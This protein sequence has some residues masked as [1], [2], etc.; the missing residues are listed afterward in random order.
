MCPGHTSS[1][2]LLPVAFSSSAD[3]SINCPLTDLNDFKRIRCSPVTPVGRTSPYVGEQFIF[4]IIP[5]MDHWDSSLVGPDLVT[6][7][8]NTAPCLGSGAQPRTVG[9]AKS[10]RFLDSA[11]S[12][13]FCSSV[14]R[15]LAGEKVTRAPLV[16]V[17]L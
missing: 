13:F 5:P 17:D 11:I 10:L 16:A 12:S 4:R 9:A 3:I 2:L 14:A 15:I 6:I 7:M 1:T 8:L